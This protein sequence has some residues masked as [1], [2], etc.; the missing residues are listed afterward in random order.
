MAPPAAVWSVAH[1][2]A[3]CPFDRTGRNSGRSLQ[4]ATLLA[5]AAILGW[6]VAS[7]LYDDDAHVMVRLAYGAS[8]GFVAVAL[9]A[10]IAA[11]VAGIAVAAAVGFVV[12]GTPLT[13]LLK[14]S[15][16]ART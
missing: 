5:L 3:S 6:T 4:I 16:R 10:F 9:G 12:A 13:L 15:I 14:Q 8:T 1:V 7:Y 2:L 11:N